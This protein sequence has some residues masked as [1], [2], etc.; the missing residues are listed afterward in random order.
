MRKLVSVMV[1]MVMV[2]AFVGQVMA[3][4]ATGPAMDAAKKT[5]Q[6]SENVVKGSVN[7]VG[8]AVKGTGE[9]AVSPF[10][11]IGRWFKGKGK[12]RNVV[13]DPIEK[14]GKTVYDATVNTGKTV[15]GTK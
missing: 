9:V 15:Q 6:Y 11:A 2:F 7:T 12:A 1:V 3:E 13:T 5:T 8:E 14:S 10:Q 4:E